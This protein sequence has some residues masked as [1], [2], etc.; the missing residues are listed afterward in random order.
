M[1]TRYG[2]QQIDEIGR[3]LNS[4]PTQSMWSALNTGPG[5]RLK[6]SLDNCKGIKHSTPN[7]ANGALF[8]SNTKR[9]LGN[10]SPF[11]SPS[12][13]PLNRTQLQNQTN[14]IAS[15]LARFTDTSLDSNQAQ[16]VHFSNVFTQDR[17]AGSF[18]NQKYVGSCIF[19]LFYIDNIVSYRLFK[20]QYCF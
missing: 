4:P 2:N 9:V 11:L 6:S 16:S 14:S 1:Q 3:C 15:P 17:P 8:P 7:A 19:I 18:F 10:D 5:S 12:V 20:C 13:P